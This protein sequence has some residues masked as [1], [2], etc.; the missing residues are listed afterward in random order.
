MSKIEK[1]LLDIRY[2]HHHPHNHIPG[3]STPWDGDDGDDEN[4]LVELIMDFFDLFS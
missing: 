1:H 3:I 2:R 4:P